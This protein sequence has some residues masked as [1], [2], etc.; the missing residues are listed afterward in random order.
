MQHS[1]EWKVGGAL[2]GSMGG[3]PAIIGEV[4]ELTPPS[5]FVH[6]FSAQWAPDVAADPRSRV[7]WDISPVGEEASKLVLAHNGFGG[8]TETSKAVG[9]GRP[10]ALSR[11]KTRVETGVPFRMPAQDAAPA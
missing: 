1:T 9:M 6:A 10:E 3:R 7:T 8:E 2:S 11:F 4:L 5:R